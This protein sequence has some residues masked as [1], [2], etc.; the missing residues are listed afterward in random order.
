M[1]RCVYTGKGSRR[2]LISHAGA[3]LCRPLVLSAG[4]IKYTMNHEPEKRMPDE[5]PNAAY[6][7]ALAALR[8]ARVPHVVGGGL[9]IQHYGRRRSTK[10]LD[11]FIRPQDVEVALNA[12]AAAGFTTM[13]TDAAWLRKAVR[14]DAHIDLVVSSMGSIMLTG[15]EIERSLTVEL[16]GVPMRIFRPEDLLLRKIYL[17]RDEGPDWHDAFSILES[18]GA[19][20]NWTMVE[21]DELDPRPLAGFLLVAD[22][23]SPGLIPPHVLARYL[24]RAGLFYDRYAQLHLPETATTSVPEVG[25][26]NDQHIDGPLASEPSAD[27]PHLDGTSVDRGPAEDPSPP[28]GSPRPDARSA[29]A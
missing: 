27:G 19:K 15:D 18:E 21:R 6:A 20:L 5:H 13:D 24:R 28:M 26:E 22:A 11:L 9:A 16:D 17:I 2:L 7:T 23:R 4:I 1:K 12:L 25:R 14:D 29:K 3:A 10:D 8:A